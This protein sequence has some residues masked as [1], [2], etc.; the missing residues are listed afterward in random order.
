MQLNASLLNSLA[1]NGL[2]SNSEPVE[3]VVPITSGRAF[4]WALVLMVDGVDM[5][6][7][8]TGQ[9][10]IDREEGAAGT[11]SFTL[12]LPSGTVNPDAW[13]GKTVSIDYI[14]TSSGVTT[15]VR[16]FTGR[17]ADPTYSLTLRLLDCQ[18]T[19]QLQQRVEALTID[20]V[21][22]LTGGYWSE[23]VYEPVEGRSRW[24]YAQERLASRPV[25]LE[26]SASGDLRVTSWFASAP[27][28]EFGAGTTVFDS[29]SVDLA[30]L[31]S[32]VNKIEIEGEYRFPRLRQ[33][34]D[35]LTW[36]I[37]GAVSGGFC[38]WRIDSTELPDIEMITSATEGAGYVLIN[39]TWGRLPPDSIDP[40]GTGIA[41][42]NQYIDLLL[43][44]GW[45]GARRWTQSI[46]EKYMLT[47][48]ADQ[49]VE[50]SGEQISRERVSI[51]IESERAD[52]WESDEYTDGDNGHEDIRD[53]PRRQSALT[54]MLTQAQTQIYEAHRTT[55][56]SWTDPT[57]MV[58]GVDLI[59]T[60]N[61]D[62]QKTKALGKCVRLADSFDFD[63]GIAMTTISIAV[64]RG[65]GTVTD[66]LI[67]PAFSVEPQPVPI[68]PSPYPGGL[69]NQIGGKSGVPPYDEEL[70]GFSGNFSVSD[71]ADPEKYPRRFSLTAPEIEA[72]RR[73][74]LEV[75]IAAT[76]RVSVPN[77]LLELN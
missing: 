75:P 64:M 31:S 38:N 48:V 71:T 76:Y 47:V 50:A 70:D 53:E 21:D 57:S 73:D 23:D 52:S 18:C 22:S 36:I 60:I 68:P 66:P 61:L 33:Q 14:S 54:C 16:R 19:D 56:V 13:R 1:L 39:P 51:E 3:P 43:S 27:A 55:T 35:P 63:S 32:L 46:T 40:C 28:F 49:S 11:A 9:V 44:A 59:H 37:P 4:R 58:M 2:P 26:C 10:A 8:L 20:Q 5:T 77:D 65:G 67:V 62:D 42:N 7:Q 45:T 41:W 6:A 74:E 69:P 25:S 24:D 29:L 72:G 34:N 12:H 15:S 17:I 30:D